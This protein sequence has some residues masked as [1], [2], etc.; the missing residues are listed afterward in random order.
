M[1]QSAEDYGIFC[2]DLVQIWIEHGP[3]AVHQFIGE[4]DYDDLVFLMMMMIGSFATD[5]TG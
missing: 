4:M 3:Q 5:E 2:R 1:E